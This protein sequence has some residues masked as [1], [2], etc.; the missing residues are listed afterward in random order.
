M[1]TTRKLLALTM[2]ASVMLAACSAAAT[3]TPEPTAPPSTGPGG[4]TPTTDG[5]LPEPELKSFKLG[6]PIGEVSQFNGILAD[7]LGLYDK[8]GIDV[9]ITRFNA[10]G[11]AS[12]AL[13]AGAT[14]GA[15]GSGSVIMLTSQLT[16]DDPVVAVSVFKSKVFDGIFCRA[17]IKTAEQMKGAQMAISTLGTTA[18]ASVN[19]A[20]EALG[21]SQKD[22][23]IIQVGGQSVRLAAMKSGSVDCAPVSIDLRT[24]MENLGF[25]LIIDLSQSDLGYPSTGLAVMAPFLKQ[26]PNT[27]R[28]MAAAQLEAQNL[29]VQNPDLAAEKWA[30][31]A[32]VDL[33]KAKE[34]VL[35]AGPQLR[36]S[37]TCTLQGFQFSQK[38]LAIIQPSVMMA[39]ASKACDSSVLQDLMDIGF[40]DKVGAPQTP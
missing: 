6:T 16:G 35:A 9:E 26:Y 17:D 10:G 18:H 33:A 21:M 19:L 20:L 1:P 4:P 15:A 24:D 37:M 40:Y 30:E 3:P 13:I 28:V 14:D 34:Q 22:V 12:Q 5:T 11:D 2:A 23:N 27:V 39:D 32:Q 36:L 38:T 31:F 8:Y 25:N 29:M 7:M